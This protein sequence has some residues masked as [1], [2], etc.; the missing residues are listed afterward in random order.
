MPQSFVTAIGNELLSPLNCDFYA[1]FSARLL[2]LSGNQ[3]ENRG[4]AAT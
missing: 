1:V 2:V 4:S 3:E